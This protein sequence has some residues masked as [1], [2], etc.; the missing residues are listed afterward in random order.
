MRVICCNV[1]WRMVGRVPP[2]PASVSLDLV[3][4]T[5]GLLGDK[6][7]PSVGSCLSFGQASLGHLVGVV[8]PLR[9]LGEDL[10]L[11]TWA[12]NCDLVWV[13]SGLDLWCCQGGR[14]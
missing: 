12:L 13:L 5:V 7:L 11:R 4:W 9:F 8:L 10:G 3:T 2:T 14:R 6:K 1:C